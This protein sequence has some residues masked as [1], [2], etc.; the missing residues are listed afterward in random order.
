MNNSA[1]NPKLASA[2][3]NDSRWQ[4]VVSRDPE[5]DGKFYYSVATTGVYCR[6]SCGGTPGTT[7]KRAISRDAE[8]CGERRIPAV[9]ALQTGRAFAD[10]EQH[11]A[12]I[13]AVCRF[14]ENSTRLR[15]CTTGEAMRD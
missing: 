6:P 15:V 2:T 4:S 13:A 11:A 14:I 3:E 9:Q 12:K 1:G 10:E 5:A 8:G 7:G